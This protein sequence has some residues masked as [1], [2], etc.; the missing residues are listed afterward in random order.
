VATIDD[1]PLIPREV[2]FG[3]PERFSPR[4]SPDG[5][6]LAYIAPNAGVL[7][8]WVRTVGHDDDT[9]VTDDSDR[10]IRQFFW[11]PNGRQILYLQDKGGDENWRL[12]L[13]DLAAGTT[14][15]LTPFEGVQVQVIEVHKN[16]PDAILVAIN[17]DNPQLHDPYRVDLRTGEL[18]K[19]VENPGVLDWVADAALEPRAGV[20]P[21][22]DGGGVLRVRDGDAWKD[23]LVWESE[24]FMGSGPLGFTRDGSALFLISS[25]GANAARLVRLDLATG[26]ETV[27]ATDDR[28]DV[29]SVTINRDTYEPRLVV[30]AKDRLDYTVLEPEIA[31]DIAALRALHPGDLVLQGADHADRTWLAA[32]TAGDGPISYYAFDRSTKEATFLFTHRPELEDYEL[33][34]MEPFAYTARDGLEIHGYLTFP[35]RLDRRDL[36]TVLN[37]HGGPWFRDTWG[38]HPEAQFLANRGYLCVQV[39]YRGS[40]G[41][42]KDF[43][44]AGDR[45][46]GAKMHTDLIDAVDWVVQQGYADR[47]RLAIYGG[48]YGGFAALCGATFTPDVFRCAVDIVGVVNLKT[49]IE[50]F[51]PYWKPMIAMAKRRVGDPETEAD[52]LWSRSPLSKADQIRIPMLIA[53]GANDPRVPQAESEQIVAAMK[54][55][56]VDY[57]YMLFPDEGHGFAKPENSLKFAAAAERF[58]AA[59][60]GGRAEP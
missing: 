50:S 33:A 43:V 11:A 51:P 4:I 3:N 22:P 17:K 9:V 8:I 49:W 57:E 36:P 24:D 53:Q 18:T 35:P 7:N 20:A 26:D 56:G 60:L 38:F 34:T 16:F 58:L 25:K 12:Y 28:Y 37:V 55:N 45:E 14:R 27:L 29:S 6:R 46:W 31:D 44:N 10:G 41:Y 59:H 13:T 48:S 19:L 2:L 5:T 21:T 54:A 47:D 1:V 15:D 23:V 30:Y 52:F 39:N 32:F 40:V 42:G